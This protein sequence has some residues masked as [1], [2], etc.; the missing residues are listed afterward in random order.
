MS[1]F[2]NSIKYVGNILNCEIF[3]VDL[4]RDCTSA[5]LF[6]F[7]QQSGLRHRPQMKLQNLTQKHLQDLGALVRVSSALNQVPEIPTKYAIINFDLVEGDTPSMS[8]KQYSRYCSHVRRLRKA[9][10]RGD[11]G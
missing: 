7:S 1:N 8:E 5:H 6:G 4:K 9:K 11:D 3:P 2:S 10:Q